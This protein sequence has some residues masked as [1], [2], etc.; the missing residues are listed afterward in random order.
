[1]GKTA[2]IKREIV[3]VT[4]YSRGVEILTVLREVTYHEAVYFV[5]NGHTET[6]E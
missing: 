1:M 6:A 4:L 3:K 5:L 2:F